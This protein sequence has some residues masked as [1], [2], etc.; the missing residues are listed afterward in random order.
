MQI[1]KPTAKNRLRFET[2]ETRTP[3]AAEFG[4]ADIP[5][6]P[7]APPETPTVAAVESSVERSVDES[8]SVQ[9][10][11]SDAEVLDVEDQDVG[12]AESELA[13]RFQ[14]VTPETVDPLFRDGQSLNEVLFD[15]SGRV[16]DFA[17][18]DQSS[19]SPPL[20]TEFNFAIGADVDASDP[21]EDS[22][23]PSD[24]DEPEAQSEQTLD[25]SVSDPASTRDGFRLQSA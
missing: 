12:L 18:P 4:L 21:D 7:P 17:V 24:T 1:T 23:E 8:D 11:D 9:F 19:Q 16:A 13:V 14:P 5:I 10:A 20:V 22:H 2:L 6:G 15:S 25:P 3:L